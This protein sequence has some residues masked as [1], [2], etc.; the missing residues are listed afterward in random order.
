[1]LNLKFHTKTN[2]SLYL[3]LMLLYK[4]LDITQDVLCPTFH[5]SLRFA[6]KKVLMLK[7]NANR[8]N[9]IAL[10]IPSVFI[11]KKYCN[12]LYKEYVITI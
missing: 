1:M 8:T 9:I 10:N 5:L 11:A 6:W 7:G 2:L 3:V 4:R 12:C